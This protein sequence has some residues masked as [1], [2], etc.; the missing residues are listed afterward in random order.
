MLTMIPFTLNATV[1]IMPL[2]DSL[3]WDWHYNDNRLD[4]QRSGYRNYLWYKLKNNDFDVNFVGSRS[5]GGA[6]S[7]SFDGNNDGYTG[8]TAHQIGSLVYSKLQTNSPDIILLHIGTNDYLKYS[9][10]D[11]SGIEKILNEIDRYERN[12]N[13]H[14]KVILARIVYLPQAGN[15]VPQFNDS[16]D[17]MANRR[18]NNGDDIV[19]VNMEYISDLIDGI[20][21]NST[22]YSQ[23]ANIWYNALKVAVIPSAPTNPKTSKV[24]EYSATLTWK[25]TSGMEDGYKVYRGAALIKTLPANTTSY[26]VDGLES[27]TT[28]TYTIVAYSTNGNAK[29]QN[30]TFTTKDD[31]AW[32]VP[33]NYLILN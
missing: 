21:P 16:I 9:P 13:K 2:G 5:N 29:G 32:L 25:D 1:K 20:H 14:I 23:M 10:S 27:R 11:M 28:Y 22:G 4:S 19:V 12:Y 30:I 33:I 26:T 31:Y 18:I 24:G 8:Y 17:S 6:V 7:P 3:T 15:W